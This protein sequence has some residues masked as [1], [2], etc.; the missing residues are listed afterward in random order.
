LST[1]FCDLDYQALSACGCAK[2][3]WTGSLKSL[4]VALPQVLFS[5]IIYAELYEN[6]RRLLQKNT[7]LDGTYCTLIASMASRFVVT[8]ANVPLE[9][10][11]IKISNNVKRKGMMPTFHGYKITLAR[12]LI[13]SSLFWSLL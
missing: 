11:R 4:K 2:F 13:Y 5:N 7:G 9:S 10:T 8:T 1:N 6:A 12:D 3:S